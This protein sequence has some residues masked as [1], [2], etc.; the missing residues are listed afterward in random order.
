[1]FQ[2]KEFEVTISRPI[3]MGL[4]SL[5]YESKTFRCGLS[6]YYAECVIDKGGMPALNS[7]EVTIFG[8]DP[9]DIEN[10]TSLVYLPLTY[11]KR[12]QLE[13]KENGV[14][15]FKGDCVQCFGN[16]SS[17]PDVSFHIVAQFGYANS[18][19][20]SE[21]QEYKAEQNVS[22]DTAF[23]QYAD[24]MG[25][26]FFNGGVSGLVP[27]VTLKGT[28]REQVRDLA[29]ACQ[30]N[31]LLIDDTVAIG[32][33]NSA[34][35]REIVPINKDNGLIGYPVFTGTGISFKTIFNPRLKP[36]GI[37]RVKSDVPRA[38]GD[39]LIRSLHTK[40]SSF[41]NGEWSTEVDTYVQK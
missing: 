23:K 30:V 4:G 19:T 33:R 13:V 34:I 10:Y 27:D 8:V 17:F 18:I 9:A 16:Y 20:S 6:G 28:L 24:K 21:G 40:L 41:P 22:F 14:T 3:A 37:V 38:T 32:V 29:A 39:W 7:C 5:T 35:F 31:L 1:M 15:V 12:N 36:A 2:T 26:A 25:Y 11:N